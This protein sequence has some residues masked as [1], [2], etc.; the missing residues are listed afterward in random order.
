MLAC[1]LPDLHPRPS[2]AESRARYPGIM[3]KQAGVTRR[4]F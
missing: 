4:P 3:L 1:R 2:E